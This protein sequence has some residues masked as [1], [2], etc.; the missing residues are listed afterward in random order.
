MNA[1][2]KWNPL[3]ELDEIQQRLG[4][5]FSRSSLRGPGEETVTVSEWTPLADITEDD[6]EY[7]IKAE[8][9]EVKK[10]DVK[11]TV[12]NGTLTMTGERKFEKGRRTRD[13]IASNAHTD[14]SCGAS[15]FPKALLVIR[16]VQTS[17]MACSKCT[18]QR[19]A[20]ESRNQ[21]MSRLL[22]EKR[23]GQHLGPG[24]MRATA[25]PEAQS[26]GPFDSKKSILWN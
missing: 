16:L 15:R 18:F 26:G 23:R 25:G 1:L 9:P 21:S 20:R 8:L 14:R 12:E 5:L 24:I 17:R 22:K 11:V 19:A 3:R 13:A 4:S 6:K 10:E 2:M 7:L